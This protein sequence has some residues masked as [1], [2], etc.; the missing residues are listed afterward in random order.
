VVDSVTVGF[1]RSAGDTLKMSDQNNEVG[2]TSPRQIGRFRAWLIMAGGV[3]VSLLIIAQFIPPLPRTLG[4]WLKMLFAFLVGSAVIATVL[5]GIAVFFRWVFRRQN[6]KRFIFGCVCF[7]TLIALFYAEEDWRGR[8]D[9]EKFKQQWEAKGENFDND[10]VVPQPV[11]DDEN[12]AMSPVWVAELKRNFLTE[13]KRAED[14]YGDRIYSEE[15]S[16]YFRLL[17]VS[18]AAV[19]GTNESWNLP[20]TPDTLGFWAV[21]RVSDL[22]PWQSF[23]RNLEHTHPSLDIAITSKPQTPAQDVLL[24][25]SKYDP[26]IERLR[27][28]SRLPYSRF[29]VEY[30]VK[31]KNPAAILLPHLSAIK[32]CARVLK[33]RAIA[34]LQNGQSDKALADVELM[35]RLADADRVEPFLICHLVRFAV[36]QIAIQPIYEG[37]ADHQWSDSQLAELD[38][39]LSNFD[40]LNDYKFSLRGEMIFLEEG[41]L[42]FLRRHP[43]QINSLPSG[44]GASPPA[45]NY[46]IPSG[47][48]YQN[49]LH[50]IRAMERYYLPAVDT[51][52][53]I[54]SPSAIRAAE[55]AIKGETRHVNPYDL[56][57]RMTLPVLTGPSITVAYA[58]TTVNLARIAI[59]LERY[60]LAHGQY[61]DSLDMLTPQFVTRLPHDII[62]GH[63]LHYQ[64]T[65][66]GQFILYSVGWNETDDGGVVIFKRGSTGDVDREQGDWVWRYPAAKSP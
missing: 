39:K 53:D 62:D 52:Q 55:S 23:Y 15:V 4:D 11:P 50:S 33:L 34:E 21:A 44:T 10:S 3:F 43:A 63:Q 45:L 19:I 17:P 56:L 22:R 36:L 28:D 26:L 51:N 1:S 18:D 37:L 66:E 35:F 32:G 2:R 40:L 12:F 27:Q 31:D 6:F 46:V 5:V 24:A 41:V 59:A 16:N 14:W 7:A 8:Y 54:L 49:E 42:D 60:R 58:Q 47:W 9:W 48:Y 20:S 64:R 61:P 65:A 29:P 13:P 57:E 25:L 30:N 38:S